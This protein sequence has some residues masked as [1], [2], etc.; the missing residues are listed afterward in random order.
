MT[1]EQK[2]QHY[3]AL[4][5]AITDK[6]W[7]C[8]DEEADILLAERKKVHAEMHKEIPEYFK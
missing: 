2:V 6:G 5:Q 3:E 8:T 4:L 7:E 1:Y